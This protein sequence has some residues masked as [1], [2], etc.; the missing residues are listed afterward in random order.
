MRE[1]L[2]QNGKLA[3]ITE[4]A[5]GDLIEGGAV[6]TRNVARVAVE[7]APDKPAACT[8]A[9]HNPTGRLFELGRQTHDRGGQRGVGIQ[10]SKI[11]RAR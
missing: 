9:V 11:G 7:S 6:A 2:W 8:H 5:A 1:A 4:G 10:G 3:T